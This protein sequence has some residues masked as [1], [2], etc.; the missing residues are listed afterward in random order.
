MSQGFQNALDFY[1]SKEVI[2]RVIIHI[3][4]K[5]EAEQRSSSSCQSREEMQHVTRACYASTLC[6]LWA[7][8]SVS[9]YKRAEHGNTGVAGFTF[10]LGDCGSPGSF[11]DFWPRNTPEWSVIPLGWLVH[12]EIKPFSE[13]S[14]LCCHSNRSWKWVCSHQGMPFQGRRAGDMTCRR[15]THA[16]GGIFPIF[17]FEQHLDFR[18]FFCENSY[19]VD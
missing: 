9:V 1:I 19:L 4:A 12:L 3:Y 16:V 14:T 7:R 6:L 15:H 11:G 18:S 2:L 17:L 5:A 8:Q 10:P 13:Y